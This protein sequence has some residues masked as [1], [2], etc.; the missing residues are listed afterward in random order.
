M[1]VS[2]FSPCHGEHNGYLSEAYSSLLGQTHT[3]WEWILAPQNGGVIPESI[4]TDSRV[5]VVP[6]EGKVEGEDGVPRIGM[7]K[8]H[9]CEQAKGGIYAEFDSD[10][11]LMPEC[12][13]KTVAA[14]A[15]GGKF[16]YSNSARFADKTWEKPTDYA[17]AYGWRWRPFIYQDHELHENQAWPPNPQS[18]RLVMWAPN[19]IRAWEREH[20]WRVGGHDATL[21]CGDDHDLVQR[22]FIEVGEQ[23]MRHLDECLYLYRERDKK[24]TYRVHGKAIGEQSWA[25]YHKHFSDMM[26]RWCDDHGL[27]S[28]EL[29]DRTATPPW[30]ESVDLDGADVDADLRERWPFEDGEIGMLRAHHLFEHLPDKN[31]TMQELYRVLA[32]GGW[33]TI[34]VP[35]AEGAGA[36]ADPTHVSFWNEASFRY[37]WDRQKAKFLPEE[38]RGPRFQKTFGKTYTPHWG[39]AERIKCA[40]IHLIALKPPYDERPAGEVLI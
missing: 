19:H 34:E 3:E 30:Q 27:R 5:R 2:V 17:P 23:G 25:N 28:I 31:H 33:A 16:V 40:T 38:F 4:R 11:L 32:P 7:L 15:D 8:R 22:S 18:M 36:V 12:L 29:G 1:L 26:R 37:Y 13:A 9:C 21:P 24:N 14:V 35:S 20:Y 39:E 6:F 10:D